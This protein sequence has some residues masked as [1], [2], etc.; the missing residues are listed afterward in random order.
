M[1]SKMTVEDGNNNPLE[2]IDGA[3]YSSALGDEGLHGGEECD[4]AKPG[5]VVEDAKFEMYF[6]VVSK[7]DITIGKERNL[8]IA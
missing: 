2:K 7:S 3:I 1:P 8:L 5:K 4:L 6:G